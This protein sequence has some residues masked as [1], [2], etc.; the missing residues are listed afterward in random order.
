MIRLLSR[1]FRPDSP[2]FQHGAIR[3][4]SILLILA[5]CFII[6]VSALTWF[7]L[8]MVREKLQSDVSDALQIVLL[9]TRESLNLWVESNKFHLTRLA[10]DPRLVSLTERQLSVP[11]NKSALLK[12]EA[13]QELRAFFRER[14]DQFGEAGFFIISSNFLN[15]AS[16]RDENIGTRNLVANQALDLLN[17]AFRGEALMVPPIWSDIPL[18]TGTDSRSR[19][20]PSMFFAAPVKNNQGDVIAVVT[21]RIDPSRNF[22]RLIQLGRIG[23]SGETYAFGP[24]GKLLSESRFNSDLRKAGLLKENEKSILRVSVRDPGGDTTKGYTPA[25][26]RYQQ[27]LTLMAQQATKGKSGIN[28]EGYRDYRGVPVYGV[29]LWDDN[30]GI[31]LTTEIDEADALKPY[32]TTRKV[33]ITVLAITVLLALCSLLFAVL[34][35]VRAN[36][37][38]QKSHDKLEQR[39][40]ERT[41]E[42]SENQVRLEEAEE[43]S[44]LLLESAEEGIF[45]VGAS[46]LVNFINPAGLAMLGFESNEVIG[47]QI[48]PLIHHTRTDGTPYPVEDCPMH[49][50]LIQ[51][52][53]NRRDDEI[54]WRKD[55]TSFPVEYTS[56]PIRK[57]GSNVGT[58]VVFRNI[59]ERK[60]AERVL[61]ESRAT[62]RGLLDATQESLLLLD[63]EGIIVAINRTAASRYRRTPK[64]LIGKN[65]FD[66]L[67]E[68]LRESRRSHFNNV[69]QTGEPIDFEDKRDGMNFYNSFYPVQDKTGEIIGVAIFGQDVTERK[70]MEEALKRNV[71]ELERFSKLAYGREIKMIQLKKEINELLDQTGQAKKYTIVK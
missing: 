61:K 13:L 48:H 22:T 8:G 47:Q 6:L 36:Q 63:K 55:G 69:L 56:V 50:S 59:S 64:E 14:R 42:L 29:W 25:V 11:R 35:E 51:G 58:V 1:G 12:S 44:R 67:P 45:G 5:C 27:P 43:R 40:E 70:Q 20:S 54:L 21:Q 23:E 7:A 30:L 34:I 24:Y 71:E 46:G 41:A 39:V 38:L 4:L 2:S 62:A 32:Y 52:I 3:N 31:G 18:I 28:V 68:N 19:M 53:S 65:S 9:T 66:M 57:N 26:P 33:I 15:I 37:A 10:G 60:E 49:Q 17:R 16:M